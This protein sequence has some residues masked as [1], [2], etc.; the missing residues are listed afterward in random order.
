MKL[1]RMLKIFS[2]LFGRVSCF[3][4]IMTMLDQALCT[5]NHSRAFILPK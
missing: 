2:Y 5:E 3:A 4:R 1:D